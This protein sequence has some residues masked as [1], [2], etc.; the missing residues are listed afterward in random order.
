M[1][2]IELIKLFCL[3]SDSNEKG[4]CKA[5]QVN[6]TY[7]KI[8][9]LSVSVFFRSFLDEKDHK[10]HMKVHIGET[11]FQCQK[12]ERSYLRSADLKR[13]LKVHTAD[14]RFQCSKCDKHHS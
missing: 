9:H 3:N 14:N 2:I 13:H 12:C 8:K 1:L 5:A 7:R 6:E 10:T 11:I 4:Y